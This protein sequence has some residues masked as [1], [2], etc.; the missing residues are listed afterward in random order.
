MTTTK[1]AARLERRKRIEALARA[2]MLALLRHDRTAER[3]RIAERPQ[4]DALV[5]S[6]FDALALLRTTSHWVE[7]SDDVE[8][9]M[10]ALDAWTAP[11]DREFDPPMMGLEIG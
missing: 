11:R 1:A 9:I 7:A 4:V 6:I 10:L 5:E 3:K 2:E 8:S